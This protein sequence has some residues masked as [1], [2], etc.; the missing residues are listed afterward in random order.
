V[1]T[2]SLRRSTDHV[3][4]VHTYV[5]RSWKLS[6]LTNSKHVTITKCVQHN[7][8]VC[9]C[10]CVCVHG[11]GR[12]T[13]GTENKE[14]N[15]AAYVTRFTLCPSGFWQCLAPWVGTSVSVEHTASIFMAEVLEEKHWCLLTRLQGTITM[16]I[17]MWIFT[18]LCKSHVLHIAISI[19]RFSSPL[20]S[21]DS[22]FKRSD[23][24]SFTQHRVQNS[25]SH[26]TVHS[27]WLPT[28]SRFSPA[29]QGPLSYQHIEFSLIEFILFQKYVFGDT[30]TSY[31]TSQ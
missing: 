3:I 1:T 26:R 16:E 20:R 29:T 14:I 30:A 23:D 10:V 8:C 4:S 18:V 15:S 11:I 31:R 24:Y 6:G 7:S 21:S 5:D 13:H 2:K 25:Q 22:K 9:V 17:I 12:G 28:S 19:I 27:R